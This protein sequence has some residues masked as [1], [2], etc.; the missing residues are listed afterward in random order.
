MQILVGLIGIALGIL[1]SL[2]SEWLIHNVGRLATIEKYLGTFGGSRL[3]YQLLGIFV[4]FISV[5]Y[6][7]GMLGAIVRRILQ[8][9]FG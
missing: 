9:I 5:L 4:I 2:K 7:L 8:G 1:I 3:F 6:M